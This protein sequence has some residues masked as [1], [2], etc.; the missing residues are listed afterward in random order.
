MIKKICVFC[1]SSFGGN[2]IYLKE[3]VALGKSLAENNIEL[4]YGGGH[5]GLMGA[6]AKS[7]IDHS[8][9]V[10]GVIPQKIYDQVEHIELTHLHIVETMHERKHKMYDLADAFIALP[11]GIGT[12]EE[13]AE[14]MTWQQIGYHEKPV[15]VFNIND[16]YE[17]FQHLLSH[18]I[19]EGFLKKD[20]IDQLVVE[21]SLH[22][23]LDKISSYEPL[24]HN[25]WN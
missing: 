3:V 10:T 14:I 16:F 15:G 22:D 24:K 9:Q 2:N 18:M 20:F 21:N 13:L 6:L 17:P 23:L 5:S 8:G 19:K 11:G 25:K 12:L 7:V 4:V 1:G